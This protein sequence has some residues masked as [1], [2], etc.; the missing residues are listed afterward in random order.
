MVVSSGNVVACAGTAPAKT[1]AAMAAMAAVKMRFHGGSLPVAE[2][3]TMHRSSLPSLGRSNQ[4]PLPSRDFAHSLG[5]NAAGRIEPRFSHGG[6]DVTLADF[7]ERRRGS[8]RPDV[9]LWH[10]VR[11]NRA[12]PREL[13]RSGW[14]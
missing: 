6:F 13:R 12:E 2:T 5:E 3:T 4:V 14:Q 10:R 1:M 11:T 9:F 7:T 8:A